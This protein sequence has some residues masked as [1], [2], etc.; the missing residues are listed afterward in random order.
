MNTPENHHQTERLATTTSWFR[1]AAPYIH[2]HRGA[3]FVISFD[4]ETFN[5]ANFDALLHDIAILNSL[6]IKLILVYGARA[7]IEAACIEKAIPILYQRGLRVTD[8]KALDVATRIIG[9][10][11]LQIEAKFS[12]GLPHTPMADAQVRVSSGNFVTAKPVGIIDGVDLGHTGEVRRVDIAG[13]QAQLNMGNIV[14]LPPLGYSATGEMFNLSS[15]AIASVVAQAVNADKLIFI[16]DTNQDLPKELT[17][18]E[19]VRILEKHPSMTTAVSA[20]QAGVKRVHLLDRAID[21]ALLQELFSRDGAGTLIS[22]SVFETIRKASIEDVSGI[23][24]LISPLEEKGIVVKRSRELLEREI[25]HFTVM[26]RDGAVIGCAAL[27]PHAEHQMAELACLVVEPNYQDNGRGKQ[28]LTALEREAVSSGIQS[29]FVLTTQTAHWFIEH[30]FKKAG[31]NDLPEMKQALYN[32]Q[33]NSSVFHKT[34]KD[35]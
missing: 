17:L 24:E 2:A 32:Y 7:Q 30:G 9:Q 26:E 10:L 19:A 35:L 18:S 29:I 20:C 28:L 33:R 5:S 6:G 12:F 11:R 1:T 8:E 13:I 22:A 27:Y 25:A 4:G 14:L 16:G 31:I 3:T 23:L 34:L 15:K 21:G